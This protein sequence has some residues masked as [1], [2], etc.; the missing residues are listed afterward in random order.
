MT[1]LPRTPAAI[2]FDMDG[3]LFDTE[4]LYRQSFIEAAVEHGT[5]MAP[6]VFLTM[7]GSPWPDNR[8]RLLE[9]YGDT[10]PVDA[11]GLSVQR[12]FLAKAD[13]SL[14]LKPGVLEI[15][16]TLDRFSIPHAIAT[17]SGHASVRHHLAM[18]GLSDRFDAIVAAGDYAAGKPA[19]DPYLR[20]A[21][22]LGVE[23]GSCL[24][25]ED[26]HTG[27]RSAASAGTMTIMVPDLLEPTDEIRA[28]CVHVARDLHEVRDMVLAALRSD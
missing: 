7:V 19:P 5:D 21:E 2:I 3:L 14:A 1:T 27:V 12:R 11:Y 9:I 25:L 24:A 17:S 8:S 6:S 20:A 26:S 28:L 15:L 18:H 16:D 23:P 13:T 4:A 22:R 10:F